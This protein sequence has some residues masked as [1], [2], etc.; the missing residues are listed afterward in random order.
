VTIK[1][2]CITEDPDRPT[3]AMFV[4]LK[5]HGID[6]T[7]VCPASAG[8]ARAALAAANVQL[9]DVALRRQFDLR[10][11]R[12]LRDELRRDYDI[13]HVF[14][15]KALQNGLAAARGLP[16]RVI[17]YRGI[18]GNVSVFSP[19][20]WLRFLNPRIDRVVCVANAA[21]LPAPCC[22]A[23]RDDLQRP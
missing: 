21:R 9:L 11:I 15:N 10:A 12:Q 17:A 8:A 19:I 3:I 5:R 2:L 23:L 14:G 7:V 6:L 13:L 20:S 4:G 18:V 1:A 16:V 22:G